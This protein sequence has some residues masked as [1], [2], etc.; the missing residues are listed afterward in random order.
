MT[1]RLSNVR[2]N[3]DLYQAVAVK[4]QRQSL[5]D[6][7]SRDNE[8]KENKKQESRNNF[9]KEVNLKESRKSNTSY[10]EES[11]SI[12]VFIYLFIF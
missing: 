4:S 1:I 9:C 2:V 3:G 5:I 8:K 12:K 7:C 6:V 11:D 10:K